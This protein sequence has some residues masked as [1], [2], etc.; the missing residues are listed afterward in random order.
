MD[1]RWYKTRGLE[2]TYPFGRESGM[3]S[4]VND[5]RAILDESG[6]KLVL[7][8]TVQPVTSLMY[9]LPPKK[10]GDSA[11][12]GQ[13]GLPA[14]FAE[15]DKKVARELNVPVVPYYKASL[16]Y[17]GLQCDGMHFSKHTGGQFGCFGFSVVTDLVVQTFLGLVCNREDDLEAPTVC[18]S[19]ISPLEAR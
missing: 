2:W 9:S 8:D 7:A 6:A 12:F 18:D 16:V 17:R 19:G 1:A 14:V 10:W 3:R 15:Q 4:F 13:M 5:A 11:K